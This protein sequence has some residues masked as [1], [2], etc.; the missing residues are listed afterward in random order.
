M[1]IREKRCSAADG[2]MYELPLYVSYH[3]CMNHYFTFFCLPSRL[4][5]NN[6]RA[7]GVLNKNWLREC[8]IIGDKQL[9]KKECSHFELRTSRKKAVQ[10]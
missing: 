3:I 10:L 4:G 7:T 5:V 9:Q 8:T 1:W 2:I 6:I